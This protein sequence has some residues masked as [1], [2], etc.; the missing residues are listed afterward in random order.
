MPSTDTARI[1]RR[2]RA[3]RAT[4]DAVLRPSYWSEL[5]PWL[6]VDRAL[7]GADLS[8]L[9]RVA[10]DPRPA[11][12]REEETGRAAAHLRHNGFV[13]LPAARTTWGARA[14]A[15]SG[16]EGGDDGDDDS[17]I[18]RLRRGI[19]R[20]HRAGHPASA[21]LV[22]DEAWAVQ[23]ALA[24]RMGRATGGNTPLGDWYV[25]LV[26]P[27]TL[28]E[29]DAEENEEDDDDH[30]GN[31]DDCG[32]R[33]GDGGDEDEGAG[34]S[35]AARAGNGVAA[36]AGKAWP[37]H[38]DRPMTDPEA[39][40][41]SFRADASPLYTTVWVPLTDAFPE[42]SCLYVVP[43]PYDPG[44]LG[45][46]A[47]A[48][49]PF[50]AALQR[51]AD[52]QKILALPV[53]AGAVLAF[54]HRLLHWGGSPLPPVPGEAPQPPRIALSLAFADPAFERPYLKTTTE[55]SLLF[56]PHAARLALIAAQALNYDH[57]VPLTRRQ[58]KLVSAVF[59]RTREEH[60]EPAYAERVAATA[61]WASFKKMAAAS[62]SIA[63]LRNT[64]GAP[65]QADVDLLFC[66]M[67]SAREG[68][69]AEAYL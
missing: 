43:A 12:E 3:R 11:H 33:G 1:P 19:L 66:A 30:D 46:D 36:G 34:T 27:P 39:I 16:T 41:R 38:R 32:G 64:R 22:Y 68:L 29:E 21:I 7:V 17:L 49:D 52:F 23:A 60:L 55:D 31:G 6:H 67:A 13:K 14:G 40:A 44:Y 20:L 45:G 15:G 48:E 61:S 37:P 47:V 58:A 65:S 8:S 25:F 69:D 24:D 62:G 35:R 10:P 51:P 28:S 42:Q 18:G 26:S 5:C 53:E 63:A 2:L 54:S 59:A 56:P 57:Q 50:R 9:S 4:A